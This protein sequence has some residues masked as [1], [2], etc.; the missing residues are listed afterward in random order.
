ML[1]RCSLSCSDTTYHNP[2]QPYLNK[3]G[4]YFCFDCKIYCADIKE[5]IQLQNFNIT[6]SLLLWLKSQL[7][8]NLINS[9]SAIFSLCFTCHNTNIS[10]D[11]LAIFILCRA[12]NSVSEWLKNFSCSMKLFANS[13]KMS[14]YGKS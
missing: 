3:L 8:K 1:F 2:P 9:S 11:F 10:I 12:A 13:Q 5:K 4:N 7:W 6:C 14:L